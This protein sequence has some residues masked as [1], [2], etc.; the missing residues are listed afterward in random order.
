MAA[1][2]RDSRW[3]VTASEDFY[4]SVWNAVTGEQSVPSLQHEHKVYCANFSRSGEWLVTADAAGNVRLWDG[5]TRK[6]LSPPLR[7]PEGTPYR[8]RFVEN[9]TA[10]F[11]TTEEGRTWLWRL[12]KETRSAEELARLYELVGVRGDVEANRFRTSSLEHLR[13]AWV[14]FTRE[15]PNDFKTS[16]EEILAW[17][18]REWAQALANGQTKAAQFHSYAIER[19]AR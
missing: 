11:V 16:K 6:P 9:D 19:A 10:V 8:A 2:S 12:A 17:H 13:Q 3:V 1:F 18:Q 4:A 5:A 15:H 14:K 7:L